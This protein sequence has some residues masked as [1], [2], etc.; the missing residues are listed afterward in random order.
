MPALLPTRVPH[1]VLGAGPEGHDHGTIELSQLPWCPDYHSSVVIHRS[2]QS[3]ADGWRVH[4]P[5]P[6]RDKCRKVWYC[7]PWQH[8]SDTK[9]RRE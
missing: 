2:G 4:S 7:H 8:T 1:S 9:E 6:A 5:Q 3:D